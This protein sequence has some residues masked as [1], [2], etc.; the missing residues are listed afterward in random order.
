MIDIAAMVRLAQ[1]HMRF[2]DSVLIDVTFRDFRARDPPR[3]KRAPYAVGASRSEGG[4]GAVDPG[5]AP[6][7]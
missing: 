7:G 3:L 6:T 2:M 5:P 1:E 4:R